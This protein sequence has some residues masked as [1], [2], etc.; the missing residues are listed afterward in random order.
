MYSSE[1]NVIRDIFNTEGLQ[2]GTVT[3]K[4][5]TIKLTNAMKKTTPNVANIRAR[6]QDHWLSVLPNFCEQT[7]QS[8]LPELRDY[9][10]QLLLPDIRDFG[11]CELR[12]PNVSPRS[13]RKS[14]RIVKATMMG[15]KLA[16]ASNSTKIHPASLGELV[17]ETSRALWSISLQDAFD[18]MQRDLLEDE[19]SKKFDNVRGIVEELLSEGLIPNRLG[20]TKSRLNYLRKFRE[21]RLRIPTKWNAT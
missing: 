21:K 5:Q 12:R 7:L 19:F 11:V 20:T 6:V 16:I 17:V 3:K 2:V 14:R 13:F 8:L 10:I 9:A 4:K 18:T 1:H 15:C